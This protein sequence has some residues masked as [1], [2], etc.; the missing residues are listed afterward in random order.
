MRLGRLDKR[1]TIRRAAPPMRGALNEPVDLWQDFATWPAQVIEQ[2]PTESW[3]AGQTAAQTET[4]FRLRWSARAATVTPADRLVCAGR[5]YSLIGVT[6][7]V[8]RAVIEIVGVARTEQG[9]T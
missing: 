4:V 6:E 3:K 5:E 9:L 7:V 8:R 1:V 2:R